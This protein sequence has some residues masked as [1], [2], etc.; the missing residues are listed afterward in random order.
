MNIRLMVK[1]G[2]FCSLAI[3]LIVVGPVQA[4]RF[5]G[6]YNPMVEYDDNISDGVTIL[7]SYSVTLVVSTKDA[8][9]HRTVTI[10]DG[11]HSVEIDTIESASGRRIYNAQRPVAYDGWNLLDFTMVS[12][13]V[14]KAF[15]MVGQEDYDPLDI[16]FTVGS[17]SDLSPV[18][19]TSDFVGAW[20]MASYGSWNLRDPN[21]RISPRGLET[22]TVTESGPN[23]ILITATSPEGASVSFPMRV[24]GNAA[25]LADPPFTSSDGIHHTF[26]ITSD[27]SWGS[28]YMVTT[29]LDDESDVAITLLLAVPGPG[30]VNGDGNV[31]N[32]DI[33]PF[34]AALTNTESDFRALYPDW[35]YRAA[36]A[37]GD[38]N[39]DNIDITAFITLLGVGGQAIPEPATIMLLTLGALVVRLKR[40]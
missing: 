23:E 27:G 16:S 9:G 30:D 10:S 25:R 18:L 31:D 14:N 33:T 20:T 15:A 21:E 36:D 34:V 35:A 5:A 17:W 1:L 24:S 4:D 7:Q 29:E 6:T 11:N 13:G 19:S 39:V 2:K 26:Q 28:G 8:N 40:K 22:G 37:D 32:I 3:M 38:G 12:D